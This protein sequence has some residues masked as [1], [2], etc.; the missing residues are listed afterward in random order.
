MSVEKLNFKIKLSGTFWNKR[1]QFSVWLDDA[2]V[3]RSELQA[4]PHV[5]AFE[6][7]ITEGKHTLSIRLENKEDSDVVK[8]NADSDNY[9]IIKD[10]LLNI[11]DIEIDNISL[12]KLIWETKFVLDRPIEY[13][14][15]TIT[16]FERCVNLGNNGTY[17]L[18]FSSPFYLWLLENL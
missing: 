17:I 7:D 4:D 14:G 2:V 11:D 5:V 16:E 12:G 1:P 13:Q 18:E 6:R 9:T 8:D 3:V 15:K 10:M